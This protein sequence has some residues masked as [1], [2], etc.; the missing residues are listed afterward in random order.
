VAKADAKSVEAA[1]LP[2]KKHWG[3]LLTLG[4]LMTLLGTIGLFQ[5]VAYTLATTILYGALLLVSGGAGIATSFRLEKWKAKAVAILLSLLYLA[6]GVLLL[7]YP[8]MGALSLT[9]VVGASS[10][11]QVWSK[12]GW[13]SPIESK[14]AGVGSSQAARFHCFSGS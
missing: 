1:L 8:V 11:L 7:L 12:F 14:V 13:D 6:A 9:I 3:L 5:P 10:S 2:A 4:I